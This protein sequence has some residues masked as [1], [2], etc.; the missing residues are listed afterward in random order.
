MLR[1][2]DSAS[3]VL[4]SSTARTS[5]RGLVDIVRNVDSTTAEVSAVRVS[6][7]TTNCWPMQVDAAVDTLRSAPLYAPVR[8]WLSWLL[9]DSVIDVVA[10]ATSAT[11]TTAHDG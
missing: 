7:R 1:A 3:A 6:G 2:L 4:P 10:C 8:N 5:L 9:N 11:A